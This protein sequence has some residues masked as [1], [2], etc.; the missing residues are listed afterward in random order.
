MD[1]YCPKSIKLV[2]FDPNLSNLAQICLIWIIFPVLL[3]M[4][5]VIP[6]SKVVQLDMRYL[7]WAAAG[8]WVVSAGIIAFTE[9]AS[10]MRK[11]RFETGQIQAILKSPLTNLQL[12]CA[13][14]ARGTIFGF[15][16]F[17]A[18]LLITSTLNNE[19]LGLSRILLLTLQI[20]VLILFFALLGTFT[21][22]IL[23]NAS[24]FILLTL[25]LFIFLGLGMGTF[26]PLDLF[27][28]VYSGF[29]RGIPLTGI[30]SNLHSIIG[31][32]NIFWGGYFLTIALTGLIFIINLII[33]HKYFRQ[34]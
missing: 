5:L 23:K 9:S 25:I 31:N 29:I 34:L 16:Q 19:F 6:L 28:E 13:V 32:N 4:L 17:T 10:R 33:S 22:S 21:G 15:I 18:A 14:S 20:L 8:I 1:Y 30:I 12:L 11:I 27:P 2:L 7:N 24:I 3:Q 26:I